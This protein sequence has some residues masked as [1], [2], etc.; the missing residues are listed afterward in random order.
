M[1]YIRK[2]IMFTVDCWRLVMDNRYN[3]LRHIADPSIQAYFTMVLFIMWSAYFALLAWTY[4]GWDSYS[5][6]YSIWIH[7]GVVIPM[8]LTNLTF[9]E[10]EK[11]GAKWYKDKWEKESFLHWKKQEQSY[12][13]FQ[14]KPL[15][16]KGQFDKQRTGY[17][18]GDN[19]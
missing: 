2:L 12:N 18:E 10:A 19:T 16:G 8:M 4:I 15:T 17:T 11:N 9:R 7:L 6:V 14:K 13:S 1:K 5:I 3:P